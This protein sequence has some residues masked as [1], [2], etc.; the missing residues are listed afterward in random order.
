MLISLQSLLD[1]IRQPKSRVAELDSLRARFRAQPSRR[2]AGPLSSALADELLMRKQELAQALGE[3]ESCSS[4]ARGHPLPAGRWQGG[5][6]CGGQTLN[7][8]TP[9]EVAALKL[10]GRRPQDWKVPE[11]DHA[12]CAFRGPSGCSLA[13]KDRPGICVRYICLELRAE[14]K[15]QPKWA[16][17]ADRGRA[18]LDTF[19]RFSDE[20]KQSGTLPTGTSISRSE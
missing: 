19:A 20:L 7:I 12:G 10:A 4:C 17:I 15:T 5:H 14:L 16:Q 3:V 11:A 18:Y 6:C 9:T 8:F 13:V 1:R 2:E